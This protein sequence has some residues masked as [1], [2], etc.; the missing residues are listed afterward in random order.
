[1]AFYCTLQF[2]SV[3]FISVQFSRSVVSDS[4][5]SL[6]SCKT[7]FIVLNSFSFHLSVK[8]L[9]SP[10]NRNESLARWSIL[11][12]RF[13][14]FISLNILCHFLLACR[15]SDEKSAY[16]LVGVPLS[17]TDCF[18][19][20]VFVIISLPLIFAILF[21][22]CLDVDFFGFICLGLSVHPGPGCLFIFPRR[23]DF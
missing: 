15:V 10:S 3:Q 12:C 17:V 14:S 16:N 7:G 19:L 11:G 18:S 13:F 23:G 1:M 8:L 20:D 21:I 22:T 6:I 9:F 2:S 4:L 5:W